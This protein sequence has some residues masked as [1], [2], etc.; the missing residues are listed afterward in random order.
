MKLQNFLNPEIGKFSMDAIA[1]DAEL[2][3]QIQVLLVGL[4]LLDPP[5]D[6]KF[7]PIS[8]AA[9]K[10]FQD[11][12][13]SEE[14]AFLGPK[15]AKLLIET[16]RADLPAPTLKLGNNLAGRICKY[17]Q[18]KGYKLS[19]GDNEYNLIYV[20]GMN[21]DGT[22]NQDA[23]NQFNDR[24]LVI[25]FVNGAPVIVGSWEATTEPGSKYTYHPM[26]PKG[27]A[28]IKFGQYKA[29]QVG[30]HGSDQHE[31]LVQTAA[32]TVFRD[33]NQDFQ[34][35]GD[36][37]DSGLFGVNQHWGYDLPRNDVQGA[38]AGCLVGRTKDGHREFMKLI[39]QDRRYLA[40]RNY[41]FI[42]TVI[43][44]SDLIK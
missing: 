19:S 34:R 36:S 39:K 21:A 6:G 13:K 40:N 43:L 18:T 4:G 42:T 11:L 2:A 14:S 23:P 20:E 26:N 9:L 37:T 27:A 32:I 41:T 8:I 30:L 5:T 35:A 7:G 22:L 15:T 25:E 33:F 10:R 24:R 28:R 12:T 31:A 16:K 3:R 38:S 29:W 1:A 44:G 17:M